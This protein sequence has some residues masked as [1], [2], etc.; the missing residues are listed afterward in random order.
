MT[1]ALSGRCLCG[2]VRFTAVPKKMH[3]DACHCGMCRRWSAGP[4]MGVS[5][6]DTV[7][8]ENEDSLRAYISSDWGERVFCAECGTSLFWRMRDGS[9]TSVSMN[10]FDDVSGFV[11]TDEIF[12]DEKPANYDFANATH[13][14]TGAEVIAAFSAQQGN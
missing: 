11:F 12:V 6:C 2:A 10:A 8:V 13:K 9:E 4:F 5:C 1:D 3:M 14:M 7:K